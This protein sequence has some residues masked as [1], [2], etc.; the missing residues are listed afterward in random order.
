[1]NPD[2]RLNLKKLLNSNDYVDNT[3]Q[4]RELKHS[5]KIRNDI[6]QMQNL[7]RKHARVKRNEPE[8]FLELCKTQCSFMYNNY[9][10]IFHKVYKDEIDMT[11]MSNLLNILKLI[12]DGKVDQHE[13]SVMVGKVLKK[14][15]VDSA[16][17]RCDNINSEIGPTE[18]HVFAESKPISWKQFKDMS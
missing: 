18:E 6:A 16:L 3:E 10:D 15:Y 8:R 4:I 12:E 11:I 17:K 14:L 5:D 2:E 1:M 9:T 13:G 7:R